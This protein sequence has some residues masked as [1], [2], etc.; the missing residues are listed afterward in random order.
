MF[1]QAIDDVSSLEPTLKKNKQRF[2]LAHVLNFQ[3]NFGILTIKFKN[4]NK[5]HLNENQ[6]HISLYMYMYLSW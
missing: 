6:N 2:V 1:I 5:S 3:K 4:P